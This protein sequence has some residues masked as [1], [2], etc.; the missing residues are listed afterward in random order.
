VSDNE[1]YA[2]LEELLADPLAW[3]PSQAEAARLLLRSQRS[4]V[5]SADKRNA[6]MVESMT[7]V[8]EQL[9]EALRLY[10]TRR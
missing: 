10:E 4:A 3:S 6:G 8:A 7:A 5:A 9:E 1:D 2:A